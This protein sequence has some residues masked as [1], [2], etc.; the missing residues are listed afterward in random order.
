MSVSQF[1]SSRGTGTVGIA[2]VEVVMRIITYCLFFVL[3]AC[4]HAQTTPCS[5]YGEE[6]KVFAENIC[7][8]QIKRNADEA[9]KL[10]QTSE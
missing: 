2:T 10:E 1:T 8:T 5:E 9:S 7:V 3:G 6:A 4:S